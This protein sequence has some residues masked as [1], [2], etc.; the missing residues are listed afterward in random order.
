MNEITLT[1]VVYTGTAVAMAALGWRVSARE[2]RELAAGKPTL[3]FWSWEIVMAML[4][5]IVVSSCRWLLSWDYNMYYNY[6]VS[7]QSLGEYSRDNFEPGFSLITLMMARS[8]FHFAFYFCFWAVTQVLLL[9]YALRHRKVLLP[10]L[11]LVVFL[12]PYYIFW[13]GFIRQSVVEALF[14]LMIEL[15]VRRKFWIY[16]LLCLVAISIHKM[17]VL[18]IPLYFVPLIPVRFKVRRWMP[19]APLALCIALGSYPQWIKWLFDSIGQFAQVLG[20]DHYYR[21]FS[22]HNL[23]YAFRFVMGPAR[24]CPLVCCLVVIW[25]YPAMRKTFSGDTLLSPTYRFSLVYMCYINLFANTTQYLTRPGELMRTCF[26]VMV[27]Y[28]FHYLWQQRKWLPFAIMSLC[29]FYYIYYELYK[30]YLHRGSI[31]VPELYRTFF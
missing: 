26:V 17:S 30:F 31:F 18:L 5:F 3:P 13:M 15:I 2:E 6:Y 16:L 1:L 11:A 22:S 25:Y 10:W 24:L 27:C 23:E 14:V 9:F 4:I 21:L 7:M 12:G 29:S 19:F 20:Y 28:G 8:G